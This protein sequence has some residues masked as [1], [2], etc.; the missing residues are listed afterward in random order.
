V[1]PALFEMYNARRRATQIGMRDFI[2]S[3]REEI[4]EGKT[5]SRTLLLGP[6]EVMTSPKLFPA[7]SL[8]PGS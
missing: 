1:S 5:P 7:T 6:R 3:L 8:Y 2:V 4:E